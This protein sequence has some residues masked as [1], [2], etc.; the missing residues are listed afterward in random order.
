MPTNSDF[1]TNVY[2][3]KFCPTGLAAGNTSG[4][5]LP[6]FV[7]GKANKLR[8]FKGVRNLPCGYRAQHNS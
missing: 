5:R 7:F 3:S 2:Q 1:S 6:M 4:E 8:C